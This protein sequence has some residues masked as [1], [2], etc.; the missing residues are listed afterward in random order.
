MKY[1]SATKV[2]VVKRKNVAESLMALSRV[3]SDMVTT[4]LAPQLAIVAMLIAVPRIRTGQ[5][6]QISC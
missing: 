3:R 6:S 2:R 1:S 4:K 5:N